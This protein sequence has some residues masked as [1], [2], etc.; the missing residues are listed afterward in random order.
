MK[1]KHFFKFVVTV[2][3]DGGDIRISASNRNKKVGG[4]IDGLE[5]S[6]MFGEDN[7]I[8]LNQYLH[9]IVMKQISKLIRSENIDWSK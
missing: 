6:T 2:D 1:T 9:E 3:V 8:S 5:L 4:N 7:K